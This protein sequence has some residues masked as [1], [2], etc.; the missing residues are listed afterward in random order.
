MS[1][2]LKDSL[3]R[4]GK[5]F[6]QAFL[7]QLTAS[8]VGWVEIIEDTSNLER[9]AIAGIAAVYSLVFSLVSSWANTGA[10]SSAAISPASLARG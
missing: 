8:G 7:A 1:T 5:T 6:V 2:W 9:A 4:L 10:R 3:E